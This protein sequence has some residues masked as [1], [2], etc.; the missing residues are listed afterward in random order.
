MTRD[1]GWNPRAGWCA[2][3]LARLVIC[4]LAA[5]WLLCAAGCHAELPPIR[6]RGAWLVIENQTASAWR[7]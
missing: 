5:A 2:A 1:P 7:M 6:Q 4:H 3:G